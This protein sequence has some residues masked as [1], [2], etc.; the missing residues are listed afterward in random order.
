[1]RRTF[2]MAVLSWAVVTGCTEDTPGTD[3]PGTV[4]DNP[5]GDP[6]DNSGAD[7]TDPT[8]GDNNG[9]G[10]PADPDPMNPDPVADAGPTTPAA[11]CSAAPVVAPNPGNTCAG[12]PPVPLQL[13]EIASGFEEPV[14]LTHAPGDSSRL[15]VVEREGVIRLIKDGTVADTAFLD[16]RDRVRSN[17]QSGERGL[18]GLAFDP[19][20]AE[21]GRLW[22]NYTGN[23]GQGPSTIASFLVEAGGDTADPSS[24]Q[25]LFD[26][27][28]FAGN[29]NGGMV[30]FGPDGCLY[31]ALG[32][33]GGANDRFNQGQDDSTAL[34]TIMRVSVDDYDPSQGAPG[35]TLTN[36]HVWHYGLRNPWRFSFDRVTGDMYI[37]DVGQDEWEEVDVAPAGVGSLNFGWPTTEGTEC[38]GFG[39]CDTAGLTLPVDVKPTDR[40]QSVIG[41][42]VYRGSAIPSLVGRY[43][44][45]GYNT[46]AIWSFTW[47]GSGICDEYELTDDLATGG[48]ITSF[49]EDADGELYVVA[50][51]GRVFRIDAQ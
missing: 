47:D 12:A 3:D 6:T 24:E 40:N 50:Y 39:N 11:A 49:G 18:L 29:H 22:V 48:D 30:A 7:P 37:G 20:Y 38:F 8:P 31:V 15:F 16:I 23:G 26:V 42:Y 25:V 27:D 33:G 4:P 2:A 41:G 51:N 44:Y 19:N 35:N 46:R 13:T 10:N 1:M 45:G 14:Q 17:G 28:Q 9:D 32:D 34:G 21:T 43:V 5:G 36:P